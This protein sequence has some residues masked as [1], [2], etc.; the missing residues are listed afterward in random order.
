M[1]KRA[2]VELLGLTGTGKTVALATLLKH[3]YE[4]QNAES[5]RDY[6]HAAPLEAQLALLESGRFPN[7]TPL[8]KAQKADGSAGANLGEGRT[9]VENFGFECTDADSG[10]RCAFSLTARAGDEIGVDGGVDVKRTAAEFRDDPEKILVLVVNPFLC[11]KTLAGEA[12]VELIAKVQGRDNWPGVEGSWSFLEAMEVVAAILFSHRPALY[13]STR[14]L[15]SPEGRVPIYHQHEAVRRYFQE[16][17]AD[18]LLRYDPRASEAERIKVEAVA[19]GTDAGQP[20]SGRPVMGPEV[21]DELKRLAEAIVNKNRPKMIAIREL[22]QDLDRVVLLPTHLDVFS[23]LSRVEVVDFLKVVD[24]LFGKRDR[25]MSQQIIGRSIEVSFKPPPRAYFAADGRAIAGVRAAN[26]GYDQGSW[27]D[28][29]DLLTVENLNTEQARRLLE[30]LKIQVFRQR[31]A[32]PRRAQT[33]EWSPASVLAPPPVRS[34]IPTWAAA[35][36]VL[37][38]IACAGLGWAAVDNE[39]ARP[40]ALS[41]GLLAAGVAALLGLRPWDRRESATRRSLGWAAGIGMAAVGMASLLAEASRPARP[42]APA[43]DIAARLAGIERDLKPL[44]AGPSALVVDEEWLKRLGES[45][46]QALE[47]NLDQP[48]AATDRLFDS[49]PFRAL[50]PRLHHAEI[51]RVVEDLARGISRHRIAKVEVNH[52]GRELNE[53]IAK[54][55]D[56]LEKVPAARQT[57]VAS[58]KACLENIQDFSR[59]SMSDLVPALTM[60]MREVLSLKLEPVVFSDESHL[61]TLFGP[62]Y[63]RAAEARTTFAAPQDLVPIKDDLFPE[64]LGKSL[65]DFYWQLSRRRMAEQILVQDIGIDLARLYDVVAQI[66]MARSRREVADR[67]KIE[68]APAKSKAVP[69]NH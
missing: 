27:L 58:A 3:L 43:P 51:L 6:S 17:R 13:A 2:F 19:K 60:I 36:V 50:L 61:R 56:A 30:A 11:D 33:P 24:E 4:V 37:F 48:L 34:K 46:Q 26:P 59:K 66:R 55:R 44:T 63:F 69:G 23:H 22:L 10:E 67:I 1:V 20:G 53:A 21:V 42:V 38:G 29:N 16:K 40:I 64:G 68:S 47:G 8:I 14:D 39:R 5:V 52:F 49:E 32:P 25:L 41:G 57:E 62:E 45:V 65:K 9:L 18:I 31:Y 15:G 54:A 35:L 7:Q 28:L 12:F